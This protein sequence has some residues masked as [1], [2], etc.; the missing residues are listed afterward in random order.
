LRANHSLLGFMIMFIIDASRL[1]PKHLPLECSTIKYFISSSSVN[2]MILTTVRVF[3]KV[4]TMQGT[5]NKLL[6][7]RLC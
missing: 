3:S 6:E 2:L 5:S 1:N 4:L 7:I